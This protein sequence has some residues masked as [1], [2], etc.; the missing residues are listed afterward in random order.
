MGEGI[1]GSEH[2]VLQVFKNATVECIGPALGGSG[3]IGDAAELRV[4]VAT[5]DAYFR[6][7]VERGKKLV[8][9]SAVLDRDATDAIDGVGHE[10]GGSAIDNQVVVIVDLYTRLG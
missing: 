8:D 6:D 4:V 5:A 1:A 7:G 2:R 3:D 10:G 9:R